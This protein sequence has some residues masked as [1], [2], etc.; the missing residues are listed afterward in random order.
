MEFWI[1]PAKVQPRSPIMFSE[2]SMLYL[3]AM[4]FTVSGVGKVLV[5]FVGI[6]KQGLPYFT[7]ETM[8]WHYLASESTEDNPEGV[9]ENDSDDV[10]AIISQ[11][12]FHQPIK[13]LT[14]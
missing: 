6:D 13:S 12:T 2:D 8:S 3:A 14:H 10:G 1:I 9:T 11:F 4:V 5:R 7:M